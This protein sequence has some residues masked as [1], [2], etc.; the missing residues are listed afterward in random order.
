MVVRICSSVVLSI[1]VFACGGC[2]PSGASVTGTVSYKGQPLTSGFVIFQPEV[3]NLSQSPIA[4]DG[5]YRIEGVSP[6]R[7]A[8]AVT[9]PTKPA[10]GPDGV[11]A[12]GPAVGGPQVY[13][14]ERYGVL[15][16]AGLAY[17]VS[18]V[19]PQ[20]HDIMLE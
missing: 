15:E 20:T 5:S 10:V 9:G 8:V 2:G 7:V 4:P 1:A 11:S 18:E 3:G 19:S 14:P 16:K 6:G 13:I 17:E 12:D